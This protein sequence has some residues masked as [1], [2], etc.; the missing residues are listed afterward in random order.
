VTYRIYQPIGSH[1]C[2]A[3]VG[4]MITGMSIK[5][6][7]YVVG[8]SQDGYTL[9]DLQYYL[10]LRGYMLM[11]IADVS[12]LDNFNTNDIL[13]VGYSL[14]NYPCCIEV[15]KSVDK[16]GNEVIY[17]EHGHVVYW[18]GKD[19]FDPDSRISHNLTVNDYGILK[20]IPVREVPKNSVYLQNLEEDYEIN[21]L[22]I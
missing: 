6:F 11:S 2:V 18:D 14:N 21:N 10:M 12:S 15:E 9:A 3:A 22:S 7:E 5:D 1:K 19:I 16:E 17:G 13:H 4:A 8:E 20:V